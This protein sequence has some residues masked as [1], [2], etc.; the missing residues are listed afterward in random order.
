MRV[1]LVIYGLDRPLT[2]IGRYT[3]ELAR[4]L[5]GLTPRPEV[6]L[7]C[8][9]GIGPLAE[10][11]EFQCVELPG[12][13]LL[14][15]LMTVGNVAILHA[16]RRLGLNVVHDPTGVTPFGLGSGN[17]R[18]VVTVHD[19]FAW[20]CPGTSSLL[21]TI[22]YRQW[23]PHFL[24]KVDAVIT[25][26]EQSRQ[27]IRRYLAPPA[28]YMSI[29]PYGVTARFRPQSREQARQ[30]IQQRFGLDGP[31]VLFVGALT[32]RKNVERALEAFAIVR[33]SFTDLRFV[34]AG[35]RTW[36]QTPIEAIVDRLSIGDSVHMTGSL[37]DADLPA[38]YNE[39]ELFVFP[40]LYEGF[41]LPVLEA[42]ACGTP[43]LTSNVSSLPE[44]AGDAAIL[45]DPHDVH[46]IASGMRRAL[47]DSALRA[48]LRAKGLAR[49]S[50][51]TWDR[52]ARETIAV[53]E[54]VLYRN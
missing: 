3:L 39:A 2:G 27:D 47:E 9:G 8:A 14:P 22:I 30:H 1:G 48:D 54:H 44:V 38:L 15:G 42:M 16:A 32:I 34:L 23:L 12:C 18:M 41:G 52:A 26:S 45:I 36:K 46:A 35:P 51:F 50:Q 20:S 5:S 43:V 13:R 40:S 53:Y 19:V 24:P 25:V 7:L 33:K 17:A 11:N 28:E 29:I 10:D 31:Y 4:A 6:V 37:T 49:A 21:D